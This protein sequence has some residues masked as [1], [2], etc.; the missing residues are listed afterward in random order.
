MNLLQ[1]L[2]QETC[3]SYLVQVSKA[4]VRDLMNARVQRNL[5]PTNRLQPAQSDVS[6]G[7][8]AKLPH[9]PKLS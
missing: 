9:L 2:M 1:N 7:L 6:L 5:R 4:C 3:A 8:L